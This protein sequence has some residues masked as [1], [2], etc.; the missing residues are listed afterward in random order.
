[1]DIPLIN[2]R[3]LTKTFHTAKGEA[4]HAVAGI[5]LSIHTGDGGLSSIHFERAH[6][7]PDGRGL[8]SAIGADQ[9]VDL[10]GMDG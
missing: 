3:S 10:A 5:D 4:V 6:Q 2:A 7:Q 9:A 8:A 1:M